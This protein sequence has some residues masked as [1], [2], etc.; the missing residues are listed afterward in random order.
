MRI[1]VFYI[2]ILNTNILIF[3]YLFKIFWT[4]AHARVP[5]CFMMMYLENFIGST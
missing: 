1:F 3:F 5:N 2:N 4:Y